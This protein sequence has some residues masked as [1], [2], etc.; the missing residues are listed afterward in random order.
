MYFAFQKSLFFW[1]A[2]VFFTTLVS[3]VA[4]ADSKYEYTWLENAEEGQKITKKGFQQKAQILESRRN[5]K[6]RYYPNSMVYYDIHKELYF[7]PEKGN[8]FIFVSLPKNLDA[9]LGDYVIIEMDTDKPYL[10]SKRH[11]KQFP[12]K[13][14][15]KS[16]NNLWSKVIF[17]LF[18][19][20]ATP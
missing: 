5:C 20:H 11:I 18:Y 16:K 10:Y 12:R 6:Y 4:T 13:D 17:M 15:K 9:R 2:I 8:W 14:S 7:Y 19:E 3:D 1:V